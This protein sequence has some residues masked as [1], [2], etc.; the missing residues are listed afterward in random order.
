MRGRVGDMLTTG[1]D[2]YYDYAKLYQS[3][4]GYDSVLYGDIIPEE[5]TLELK[6]SFEETILYKG[7]SLSHIRNISYILMAGTLPFI[8]DDIARKR[9]GSWLLKQIVSIS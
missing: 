4:L 5:Y 1:G 8:S 3:F 9:V 6:R 2:R 7:L